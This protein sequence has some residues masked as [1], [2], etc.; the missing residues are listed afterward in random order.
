M[1]PVHLI[2]PPE[3]VLRSAI[4]IVAAR[5]V[6]EVIA[7]WGTRQLLA[8]EIDFVQEENDAC[9]HE[10]AGVD[11]GIKEDQTLHHSVLEVR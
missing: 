9:P 6:G 8:E 4:D 2:E 3:Q 11:H 7:Q 1:R 5:I 10:P